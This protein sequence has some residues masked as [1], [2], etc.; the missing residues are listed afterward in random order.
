MAKTDRIYRKFVKR[1]ALP[2]KPIVIDEKDGVSVYF[3][4]Y[5][6]ELEFV[7]CIYVSASNYGCDPT[8]QEEYLIAVKAIET[9]LL[10]EDP[11][12]AEEEEEAKPIPTRTEHFRD[13]YKTRAR[14]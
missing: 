8:V 2:S 4:D 7:T 13:S 1:G 9:W 12:K 14:K 10:D 11:V 6:D 5:G 3:K